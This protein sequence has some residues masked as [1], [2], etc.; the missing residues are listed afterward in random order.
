M[1]A[2]NN[3]TIRWHSVEPIF[4]GERYVFLVWFRKAEEENSDERDEM[5][6]V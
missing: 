5:Q 2:F 3:S 1:V 6:S 4:Q